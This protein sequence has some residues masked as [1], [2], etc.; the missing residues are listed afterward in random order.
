MVD[1]SFA[2][3]S[4]KQP[5]VPTTYNHTNGVFQERPRR[6]IRAT[7]TPPFHG[8]GGLYSTAQ[9]F[10]LFMRM[11]LNGGRL[12]SVRLLSSKSVRLM[13]ENQIGAI[14]VEQQPAADPLLT[15]PFPLG[16]G[17][18]RFG[19]GFQIAA[20]AEGSSAYR[21]AGSLSWSGLFNTHFWIDPRR[22]VA[23]VMLMQ[24]LPFYDDGAI[25]TLREF[26]RNLYRY[27]N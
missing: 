5:R 10:G 22:N 23:C 25:R 21:S 12:G 24:T 27:L 13:M 7:P 16:A 17:R 15:N 11:M 14:F 8:D 4:E 20:R 6:P 26:E 2:V 9:D 19:L 1:T 3:A 18:D